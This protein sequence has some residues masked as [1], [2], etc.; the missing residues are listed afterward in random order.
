MI[1]KLLYRIL[2]QDM[3]KK[4][5]N[6]YKGEQYIDDVMKVFGMPTN[7]LEQAMNCNDDSCIMK[8]NDN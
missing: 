3:I 4:L 1:K 8:K 2:K 5:K 6:H 7:F